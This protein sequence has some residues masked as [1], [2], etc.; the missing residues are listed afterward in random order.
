LFTE[1]SG[2]EAGPHHQPTIN[3]RRTAGIKEKQQKTTE[4]GKQQQP[5]QNTGNHKHVGSTP[6]RTP[7]RT[8][9][10]SGSTPKPRRRPYRKRT[11]DISDTPGTPPAR[12]CATIERKE[13]GMT[14]R[15]GR[16]AIAATAAMGVAV[17]LALPTAAFA[18][19]ATQGKET[20]TTTSSGTTYYVS[21]AHGDDANAGTSENA[22]WKSLTKVNDIVDHVR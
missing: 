8:G 17:A 1:T 11:E 4:H 9:D 5:I 13:S 6:E 20:A 2:R 18:Q 7:K 16:Q 15:Q 10:R 21:S 3:P 12:R 22:P 14:S 19:S